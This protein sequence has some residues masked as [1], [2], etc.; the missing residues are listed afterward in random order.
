MVHA[1]GSD[2]PEGMAGAV[3]S[4]HVSWDFARLM[5]GATGV[6]CSLRTGPF[7]FSGSPHAVGD[8]VRDRRQA[9]RAPRNGPL[10]SKVTP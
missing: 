10:T 2:R 5:E 3:A 7:R 9:A 6:K 1:A 4:K 8:D